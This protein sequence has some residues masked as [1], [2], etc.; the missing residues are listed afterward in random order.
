MSETAV[1]TALA[2]EN[3]AEEKPKRKR[4]SPK[5]DNKDKVK[6][7]AVGLDRERAARALLEQAIGFHVTTRTLG[8]VRKG[9]VSKIET[10]A[11]RDMVALRKTI[12]DC[13]E[14]D[15]IVTYKRSIR[16]FV[17]T[18]CLP[19]F[20]KRGMYFLKRTSLEFVS[21]ELTKMKENW[22][23]LV[24]RL[25][26]VYEQAVEESLVR[27]K[28]Q[29]C[30]ADYPPKDQVKACFEFTFGTARFDVDPALKEISAALY[31]DEVA[32][33]MELVGFAAQ[34]IVSRLRGQALAAVDHLVD[35]LTDSTDGKKK[36][37]R[38][39]AVTNV[40]EFVK[41]FEQWNAADDAQLA[42]TVKTL[43]SVMDG[44][45]PQDLRDDERYRAE[46]R[47][48]LETVKGEMDK[49]VVARPV[50]RFRDFTAAD[51]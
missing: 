24:D 37:I 21:N 25:V 34:E 46:L 16:S 49:L 27:L 29:G 38:N 41:M 36:T 45:D 1:A 8:V 19:S 22:D 14:Y 5:K 48:Q 4:Q 3:A 2:I 18:Y 26:E 15:A 44:V 39:E 40:L 11:D 28:S 17:E 47:A 30:R 23:A 31:N 7:T 9:D 10:D 32:K 42:A 6:V 20:F 12:L 35:R 13:A 50:R 33:S 43:Q 51:E